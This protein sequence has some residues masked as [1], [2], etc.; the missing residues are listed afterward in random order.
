MFSELSP[1]MQM[2]AVIIGLAVLFILVM[3]NHKRNQ[4]KRQSRKDK[5]FGKSVSERRKNKKL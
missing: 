3:L 5:A 2:I 4:Q 1:E